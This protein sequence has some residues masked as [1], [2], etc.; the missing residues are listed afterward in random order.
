MATTSADLLAELQGHLER[1]AY[2]KAIDVC[3]K[4]VAATPNEAAAYK[5][6]TIALIRL[7]KLDKALEVAQ[8]FDYLK[9]E[10]AYCHY[11]LKRETKALEILATLPEK[12]PAALHLQAQAHYRLNQFD[13]VIS[14]YEALLAQASPSDDTVELKTN[15][16]AAYTAAGRG[17]E[18]AGRHNLTTDDSYEIAFNKSFV[19]LQSGDVSTA[20]AHVADADR[21]CRSTLAND[22]YSPAEIEQEALVIAVQRAYVLQLQGR[23]DDA[24]AGYTHVVQAKPSDASLVAV[25][26]NNM[27]TLQKHHDLFDSIKRLK[28]ISSET[29]SAKCS[30]AQHEAILANLA[31]LWSW[32]KK[33]DET[34]DVLAALKTAFPATALAAP[35]QLHAVLGSSDAAPSADALARARATFEAD[36]TINGRL[37]LAH[38][39]VLQKEFGA[40]AD[41]L[42]SITEVAHS[43]GTVATLVAL[44]D[45]ASN[46]GASQSVLQDALAFHAARD[47][48][49]VEARAIEEGDG[50]YQL[51]QGNHAAAAARFESLLSTGA[52]TP[53][54]RLR[55]LAKLVK[56]APVE[57][58]GRV[59]TG[60]SAM[61]RKAAARKR[62]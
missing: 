6:K 34:R 21:L 32:M 52:L 33:P 45:R 9:M 3:N 54:M 59:V 5:A 27:A 53:E 43:A 16:I 7:N 14:I 20:A 26:S 42:R 24:L 55:C 22:G 44:Y 15:L 19:A 29:L 8:R 17:A 46:A 40:A 60:P 51:A 2:Q 47:A 58:K 62:R 37:C 36:A 57:A 10:A 35:I 18:L 56:A 41:T 30:P 23:D 13:A 28:A 48:T 31:L 25:A 11:K 4:I 49:S 1:D 50:E 38:V 12:T 61:E 39:L